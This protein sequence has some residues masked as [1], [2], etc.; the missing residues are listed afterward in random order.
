MSEL[1][2]LDLV[3]NGTMDADVAAT[4]A[5]IAAERHS[6][7]VVAMPRN[8]GKTIVTR[9]MLDFVPSGTRIHNLSGS[10]KEMGELRDHPDGGY[11]VVAEFSR[12]RVTPAYI[13]GPAVR[14]V[15]H[16]LE[17]GF[18]LAVSL[19]APGLDEAFE[20][21]CL[22]NGI[23][24]SDASRINYMIYIDCF[25]SSSHHDIVRRISSVYEISGVKSGKPEAKILHRWLPENDI[26]ESVERSVLFSS[27][28]HSMH[29]LAKKIQTSVASRQTG[30]AEIKKLKIFSSRQPR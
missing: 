15:F 11:L 21:I 16:T 8:A 2:L 1:T 18:S 12:F 13:W 5:G 22:G 17:A 27:G 4:L 24:D 25:Y 23:S 3:A 30:L 7:M 19:H 20:E 14:K 26:F 10:E 6:F 29:E 28:Q 9:A